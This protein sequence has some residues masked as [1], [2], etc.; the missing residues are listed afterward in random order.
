MGNWIKGLILVSFA[1]SVLAGRSI[2]TR[3]EAPSVEDYWNQAE[4]SEKDLFDFL[5]NDF[6][7]TSER[8][9]LSCANSLQQVS[10]RYGKIFLPES[11]LNPIKKDAD[12]VISEITLLKPWKE[13]Y[14]LFEKGLKNPID[15]ES[16]WQL[17][18]NQFANE[19]RRGI[20]L[21]TALNG[22]LSIFRD[23][24]TY[25][26]PVEY[27]KQVIASSEHK[28]SNYGFFVAQVGEKFYVKKVIKGSLAFQVGL[29]KGD[30]LLKIQ[31][32]STEKMTL[33]E[34]NEI[35]RDQKAKK[36]ALKVVNSKNQK[37]KD[38]DLIKSSEKQSTVHAEIISAESQTALL[39]IDRFARSSC[40]KVKT[41]LLDLNSKNIKNLIIDLRDNP[42][43]QMDETGCIASLFTG[44]D[45]RIFSV[46]YQDKKLRP[47]SYY[48]EE[49]QIFKGKIVVLVNRGTA[50]AAEILAGALREYNK[51]LLVGE[52]TFGKGSFQEGDIWKQNKKLALFETK[53]FYYLPSG[54][55]PQKV[56]L[57]PDFQIESPNQFSGLAP[58]IGS[59]EEDQYWQPLDSGVSTVKRKLGRGLKIERCNTSKSPL[60]AT[61]DPEL[62][63]AE[64]AFNCWGL[65]T[66]EGGF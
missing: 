44:P 4:L 16:H 63:Q 10:I 35:L 58:I 28:S 12:S 32:Q 13:F 5:D 34:L 49:Q 36:L 18:N 22:F 42:G 43:G 14:S 51:A 29:R 41:V 56:G 53:G 54:F 45:R 38:Y 50:S 55:T 57:E 23:P 61:D 11:G 60:I 15:F 24:H 47:D 59:R 40:E 19:K 6:C 33:V 39:T 25:L 37:I 9:F 48:S 52:R 20:M 64:L 21:G 1:F 31:K 65:A 2:E 3:N 66:A 27:Y 62:I 46:R 17:L 7:H 26:V 30:R 8:Y